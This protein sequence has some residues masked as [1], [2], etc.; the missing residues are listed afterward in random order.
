MTFE[1]KKAKIDPKDIELFQI[2]L[3]L[4]GGKRPPLPSSAPYNRSKKQRPQE[5]KGSPMG[6]LKNNLVQLK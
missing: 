4:A 1:K 6:T 2:L 3:V 5:Q